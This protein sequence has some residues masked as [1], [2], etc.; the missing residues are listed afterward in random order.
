MYKREKSIWYN[1]CVL[2]KIKK[3]PASKLFSF[4]VSFVF[5]VCGHLER[6]CFFLI[7][8]IKVDLPGIMCVSQVL[9]FVVKNVILFVLAGVIPYNYLF[10]SYKVFSSK[11]YSFYE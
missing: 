3:N 4:C 8:C 1:I 2:H 6:S 5:D 9:K 10:S 11:K 7:F